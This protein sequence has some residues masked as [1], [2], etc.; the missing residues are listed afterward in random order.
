MNDSTTDGPIYEHKDVHIRASRV[1][2]TLTQLVGCRF[3]WLIAG[4]LMLF[5]QLHHFQ[6]QQPVMILDG[7]LHISEAWCFASLSVERV[8]GW[9][10]RYVERVGLVKQGLK[11]HPCTGCCCIF[12]WFPGV[13]C[14]AM[15]GWKTAD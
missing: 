1:G 10:Q 9:L 3:G 6:G 15:V 7:H 11:L 5:G 12:F 8:K 13:P 4:Y 2:K 14:T